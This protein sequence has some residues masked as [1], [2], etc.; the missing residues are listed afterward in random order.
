M[1]RCY[2]T[3]HLT[4]ES[5]IS[6]QNVTKLNESSSTRCAASQEK[7]TRSLPVKE[8]GLYIGWCHPEEQ[9]AKAQKSQAPQ[10][11]T[12]QGF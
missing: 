5:L 2:K 3:V 10:W 6:G 11:C 7:L 8:D 1:E 4:L 12:S 9:G